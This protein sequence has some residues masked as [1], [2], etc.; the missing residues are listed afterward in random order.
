MEVD[1]KRSTAVTKEEK[2]LHLLLLTVPL[3]QA[4]VFNK[5]RDCSEEFNF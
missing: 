1:V 5:V 3:G 4:T 2:R